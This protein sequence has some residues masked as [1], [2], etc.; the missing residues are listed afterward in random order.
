MAEFIERNK[1]E[2]SMHFRVLYIMPN[3]SLDDISLGGIEEEFGKKFCYD[4]GASTGEIMDFC[5]WFQIGGRFDSY[6]VAERGIREGYGFEDDD[7]EEID[8]KDENKFDV[9]EI[10][11]LLWPLKN[12]NFY[13]IATPSDII[14]VDANEEAAQELLDKVNNNI[15]KGCVAVIDCH[16]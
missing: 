11:D 8:K 1:E 12:D 16:D 4:C 15:I 5:D 7:V 13:A 3:V 6:L 2:N 10:K 9:A 14:E